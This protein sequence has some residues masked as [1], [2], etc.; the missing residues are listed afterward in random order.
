MPHRFG[1]V[2]EFAASQVERIADLGLKP[3]EFDV[4]APVFIYFDADIL[5][6]KAAN[7]CFKRLRREAHP[8]VEGLGR[9]DDLDSDRVRLLYNHAFAATLLKE[10]DD[11]SEW[12]VE[13]DQYGGYGCVRSDGET[14]F[15]SDGVGTFAYYGD[16]ESIR[17]RCSAIPPPVPAY[18]F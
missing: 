16:V 18:R 12:S 6:K 9:L 8:L 14:A 5:W 13:V 10:L 15:G 11:P 17:K 4:I 3:A 2:E 7:K 1:T